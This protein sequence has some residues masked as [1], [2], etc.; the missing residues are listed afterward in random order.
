MRPGESVIVR[1]RRPWGARECP[2]CFGG[3]S[4]APRIADK[5]EPGIEMWV[6][7]ELRLIADVGIVGVPNAGKST[8]LSVISKTRD[9]RLPITRLR[10]WSRISV[11]Y[12]ST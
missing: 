12:R 6:V 4:Q 1:E 11:W 9:R 3:E 2:V 7:L 8:L 5:G 10:R